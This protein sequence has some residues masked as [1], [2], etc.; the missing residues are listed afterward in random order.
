MAWI[1]LS[2]Y[3]MD[4]VSYTFVKHLKHVLFGGILSN[5]DAFL[6]NIKAT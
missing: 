2:R 4:Y 3:V 6:P 1:F 5:T